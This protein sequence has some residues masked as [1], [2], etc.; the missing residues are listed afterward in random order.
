M[1]GFDKWFLWMVYERPV[2]TPQRRKKKPQ[3]R[4]ASRTMHQKK[5]KIQKIH[6]KYAQNVRK[7]DKFIAKND[8]NKNNQNKGNQGKRK[9]KILKKV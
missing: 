3:T 7:N 4:E 9:G 6:K 8:E 1:F 2:M 5:L